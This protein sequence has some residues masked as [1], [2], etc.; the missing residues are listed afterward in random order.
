[1]T[2][3]IV[4]VDHTS[5]LGDFGSNRMESYV[6]KVSSSSGFTRTRTRTRTRTLRSPIFAVKSLTIVLVL[7][8]SLEKLIRVK[9]SRK[10]FHL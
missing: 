3:T 4:Q 1:M 6:D 8:L 10:K 9:F 5:K 7:V 2:R